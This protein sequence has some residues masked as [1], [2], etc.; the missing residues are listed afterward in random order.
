[1]M[2]KAF[3]LSVLIGALSAAQAH[4]AT[5]LREVRLAPSEGTYRVVL[6]LSESTEHELFT[7]ES[8]HRIVID[9]S[10]AEE[11]AGLVLPKASGLVTALRTGAQADGSLRLVIETAARTPADAS[12]VGGRLTVTL[13][14]ESREPRVVRAAHAPPDTGRDIVVAV[15][16]G[17]GGKD[18]GALGRG[19]TREKD[20]VL[21]I[22]RALARRIDAEPGMRAMLT[23]S[24]DHY[25]AHR[26]RIKRARDGG[27]DLFVSIH[28]DAVKNRDVSGSSVYVLSERG[29]TDE[30]A[31]WLAERENA[32]DLVGG[33]TLDDK[34]TMLAS[35]LLDLSQSAS[36]SSSMVA[37]ERVLA[38]L[39]RVG[40]VR[41]PRVQQAGFLVLKSP[42][43]PSMLVE[44]AYIS[45]P[46]EEKRLRT[47][48]H[49]RKLADAI[50]A[51]VREY[52][53]TYPPQ[54]TQLAKRRG[55]GAAVLAGA[56]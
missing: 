24:D 11:G 8:P 32:S 29:A 10:D 19:G 50:F 18:P 28:A 41:K 35:V 51:G 14:G 1:M 16:A 27:A 53:V 20:V 3:Q 13:G 21:A 2:R 54:G 38:S 49:Q 36:I 37:A 30:A 56:R 44:T 40:Q 33:V 45:N 42:D 23:R 4:A 12:W 17:H 39:V 55:T 48:A 31:R 52:F 7:L 25:I 6:E 9:L 43:I 34:D 26:E 22:A 5:Q 15:D 46:A 47:Q